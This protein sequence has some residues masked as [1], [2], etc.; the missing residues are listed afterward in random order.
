WNSSNERGEV[1]A[2]ILVLRLFPFYGAG[3]LM[4]EIVE[5]CRNLVEIEELLSQ[6]FEHVSIHQHGIGS[7][8]INRVD[9]PQDNRFTRLSKTYGQQENRKLPDA[10]FKSSLDTE[11]AHDC[12]SFA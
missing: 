6:C 12:I 5:Y 4:R 3:R 8:A 7:H 1:A 11:S 10:L 2:P 9:R